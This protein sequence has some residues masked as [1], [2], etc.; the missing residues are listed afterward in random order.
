VEDCDSESEEPEERVTGT[1]EKRCLRD[2]RERHFSNSWLLQIRGRVMGESVQE[3][4]FCT[5]VRCA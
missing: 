3:L 2:F 1:G 5:V 4:K